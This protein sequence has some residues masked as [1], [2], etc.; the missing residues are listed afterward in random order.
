MPGLYIHIPFC[1][2]KCHY[3]NFFSIASKKYINE[4]VQAI[5]TE[6]RSNS[7]FFNGSPLNTIYFGGGTPS[8]LSINQINEII[9]T[10]IATFGIDPNAE[11]TVEANPD[12]LINSWLQALSQTVVNRLSIGVQSFRNEDLTYLNRV[13]S[14]NQAESA[15]QNALKYGFK[16][17]SIDLIY[18]IPTLDNEQWI[19]NINRA[20]S[21]NIP[22]ISAYALTVEP[23]TALDLF[24][25]KGKY[26]QVEEEKVAEQFQIIMKIMAK[27]G[28]EHYEISNFALPDRYSRHNKS[29]WSGE[30]Y[31]GC[32]PS[33]HSYNGFIRRW[34]VSNISNYLKAVRE[35]TTY[36]ELEEL[37]KNQQFN[38]YIMTALR[39]MWGVD[40]EFVK[41]L[42][43]NDFATHLNNQLKKP[44]ELGLIL[45][46]NQ[47]FILSDQGKLFADGIAAELFIS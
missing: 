40:T 15:I 28:Y 2:Q 19:E 43:G 14:A 36:Y 3:C 5:Q 1:R 42:F 10:A 34:N 46:K 35:G 20:L 6:V 47:K 18:A 41:K 23:G 13:H 16:N 4:I 11:I 22:H 9:D 37:T 31:L 30:S 17:I 27:S 24:I 8:L 12:D 7:G 44:L 39:T 45:Q 21:Y 25:K 26:K 33:A 29:Y 32:G 38:E